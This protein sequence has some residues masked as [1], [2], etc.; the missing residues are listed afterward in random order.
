MGESAAKEIVQVFIEREIDS[1]LARR[2]FGGKV[3]VIYGPRQSGKTT[4]IEHYLE[5]LR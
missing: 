5:S 2:M 3:L 1:F 4:S